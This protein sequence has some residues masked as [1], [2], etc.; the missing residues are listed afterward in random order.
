MPAR[1]SRCNPVSANVFPSWLPRR[2]WNPISARLSCSRRVAL[3][4]PSQW[5]V[6]AKYERRLLSDQTSAV[7]LIWPAASWKL[8]QL[9]DTLKKCSCT[10][11]KLVLQ[12]N[13]PRLPCSN[14]GLANFRAV[15][16]V[17]FLQ[18]LLKQEKEV[19]KL[20]TL[21]DIDWLQYERLSMQFFSSRGHTWSSV[22]MKLTI[23]F[24]NWPCE[25]AG[26]WYVQLCCMVRKQPHQHY[27][28]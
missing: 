20:A 12:T 23:D 13:K 5:A 16:N 21:Y 18:V 6:M 1:S 9:H 4:R 25:N 7:K 8:G 22:T 19:T 14:N 11:R 3:S 27:N 2:R 10:Y 26:R 28:I 15:R 24:N 17:L